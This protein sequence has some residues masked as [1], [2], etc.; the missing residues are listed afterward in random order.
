MTEGFCTSVTHD[1]K[2]LKR[3]VSR[4]Q[5]EFQTK[6]KTNLEDEY[7]ADITLKGVSGRVSTVFDVQ[8]W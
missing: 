8:W 5:F 3:M 6:S 4:N 7:Q 1:D 2:N